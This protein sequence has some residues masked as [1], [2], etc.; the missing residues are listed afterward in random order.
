[1]Y[2][3]NTDVRRYVNTDFVN[4]SDEIEDL[5]DIDSLRNRGKMDAKS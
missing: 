2:F 3:N 4:F 1:M 5:S